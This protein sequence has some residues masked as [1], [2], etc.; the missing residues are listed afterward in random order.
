MKTCGRAESDFD[1]RSE[2][3]QTS[4]INQS[5]KDALGGD[6]QGAWL[7]IYICGWNEAYEKERRWFGRVYIYTQSLI[8]WLTPSTCR[9]WREDNIEVNIYTYVKLMQYTKR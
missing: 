7:N 4:T 1:S 6:G 3:A 9:M 5:K 8:K 2:E